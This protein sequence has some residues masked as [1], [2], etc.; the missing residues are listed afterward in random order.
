MKTTDCKKCRVI[1]L[2]VNCDVQVEM[3]CWLTKE[4]VRYISVFFNACK[5]RHID[6]ELSLSFTT[7]DKRSSIKREFGMEGLP[8]TALGNLQQVISVLMSENISYITHRT[9]DHRSAIK[10]LL[11]LEDENAWFFEGYLFIRTF[12]AQDEDRAIKSLR[13]VVAEYLPNVTI[14]ARDIKFGKNCI[15]VDENKFIQTVTV[16]QNAKIVDDNQCEEWIKA[17]KDEYS[18][19]LS[20]GIL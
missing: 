8:N 16:K 1:R 11:Y 9:D 18:L 19:H 2:Y 20:A 6:A 14:H 15:F 13:E 7:Y 4:E 10:R 12:C 17:V 3:L 5:N